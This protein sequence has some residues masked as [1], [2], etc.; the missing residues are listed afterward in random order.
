MISKK[1]LLV[2]KIKFFEEEIGVCKLGIHI[3]FFDN[4]LR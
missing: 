1:K 4:S 3:N 2:Y